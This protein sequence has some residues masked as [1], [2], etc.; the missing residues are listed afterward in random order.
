MN[1]S[2]CIILARGG[3]KRIPKKNIKLFHGKPII[4]YSIIAAKKSGLFNE[5]IVSTDDKEI[6]EIASK[7]GASV[8]FLRSK[9]NSDDYSTTYDVV[10][11]VLNKYE[12]NYEYVCCLYACA[13]FVNENK[14]INAF[15]KLIKFNLDC[16]FPIMEFNFPIQRAL[17]CNG[18]IVSFCN[19]EYSLV[20]SQ[21]LDKSFH[22]AG[23]FYFLKTEQLLSEKKIITSNSGYLLVDG[24][25]GQD[26]DNFID[27]KLAE[28]KYEILQSIK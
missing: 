5:I 20:R 2:I 21:D 8:P 27:W 7:C 19:P 13:P 1:K 12:D 4:E 10:E 26:I 9:K 18:N 22:D 23:Q 17:K 11:E 3:S 16:V 15:D 28:I 6:A 14:L 24:M 25:E